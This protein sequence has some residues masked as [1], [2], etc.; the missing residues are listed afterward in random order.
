MIR[1]GVAAIVFRKDKGRT[2]YLLLKRKLNWKGWEILKGGCKLFESEDKCLKREIKEEIGM[3]EFSVKK[4]KIFNKF[5]YQKLFQK[6][7]RLYSGARHRIYLVEVFSK[8][9][10]IDKKEHSGFKW[11]LQ[12]EALKIIA[13]DDQR[14]IFKRVTKKLG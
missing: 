13:W 8:R 14:K 12:K 7:N 5:K 1:K 4:T 11:V 3:S 2:K 6:D 10:K 9:I